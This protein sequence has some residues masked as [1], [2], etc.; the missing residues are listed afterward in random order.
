MSRKSNKAKE[1]IKEVVQVMMDRVMNNVLKND[2]FLPDFHKATKPLYA[3]LVPDEIF[4]GSHFERRFVTPFGGVWEKLAKV[5]GEKVLGYCEVSHQIK[6]Q[7]PKERLRRIQEVLNKLEHK[8]LKGERPR[9]NW[10]NELK[11]ILAGKG[12]LVPTKVICDVYAEN[13][14]TNEKYAFELKAPLPNSDQTK[15]SKEK[16]FKLYAMEPSPITAAYYSLPYNPYGKRKDYEWSFP[17]RWFDMKSDGVV[18][19]GDEFWNLIGGKG[20]YQLFI[21]E[22]NKLG[23]NYRERIYREYLGIEPPKGFDKNIL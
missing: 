20:T 18:L 15:V 8:P 22:I 6:G 9:P 23:K 17:A 2:P 13:V 5:V 16:I 1:A 19:I 3:A 10:A 12:A 7:I 4:K 11:Y 14:S 21:S